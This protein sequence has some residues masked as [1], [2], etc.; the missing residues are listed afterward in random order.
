MTSASGLSASPHLSHRKI[1]RITRIIAASFVFSCILL[2]FVF[3]AIR[4]RNHD[5]DWR[6]DA[7]G[8]LRPERCFSFGANPLAFE[9]NYFFA[10]YCIVNTNPCNGKDEGGKD[11]KYPFTGIH[12]KPFVKQQSRTAAKSASA[13]HP[14]HTQQQPKHCT[15]ILD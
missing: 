15:P 7:D 12:I 10:I 3:D 1:D 13:C 6:L 8:G 5:C 2:P 4:A 14:S 9:Q 11:G